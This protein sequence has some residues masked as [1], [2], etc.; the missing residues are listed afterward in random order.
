MID[1]FTRYSNAVIIKKKSSCLTAFIKNL[2]SIFGVPKRLF[3]DNGGEFISDE[4]YEMCE[5]FN[6]KVITTP[7]YSRWSNRLHK[8]HNQFLTN[9]LGKIRDDVKCDYDIALAWAVSAKNALINQ[10]DFSLAQL[11]FGK[12]SNLPSTINNH[13]PALESAIQSV[14]LTHHI[15]AIHAARKAFTAS[16]GLEKIKLALKKNIRNYQRFYEL[17]DEV[18]YKCDSSSQ[19]K[20]PAE[21]LGQDGPVL[22]LRHDARYIKAHICRVQL[23]SPLKSEHSEAQGKQVRAENSQNNTENKIVNKSSHPVMKKMITKVIC[24]CMILQ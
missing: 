12:A 15:S 8:H 21:A 24:K 17:G 5:R 16:E 18:Y 13:L 6:I 2:L 20:G 1:E 23:T 10:N 11:V 22:F 9:M 3:S 19:W 7:S 4:F 14:D